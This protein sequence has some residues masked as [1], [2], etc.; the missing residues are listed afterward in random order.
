MED[1]GLMLL[2]FTH[3][4]VFAIHFIFPQPFLSIF[5]MLLSFYTFRYLHPS[6]HSPSSHPT[7]I[8][9]LLSYFLNSFLSLPSLIFRFKFQCIASKRYPCLLSLHSHQYSVSVYCCSSIYCLGFSLCS[10]LALS[11]TFLS[12]SSTFFPPFTPNSTP[13]LSTASRQFT[14]SA[15]LSRPLALSFIFISTSSTFFPPF[16]P[17]STL[18]LYDVSYQFHLAISLSIPAL[19]CFRFQS[20][21]STGSPCSLRLH[22]RQYS[23]LAD[24]SYQFHLAIF[25]SSPAL[26]SL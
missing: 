5:S 12:T 23:F 21:Y 16:T 15:S 11:F 22:S 1:K 10:P 20:T 25:L 17:T 14:F 24:V 13:F 2:S 9:L 8:T 7:P 19:L 26:P 4:S 3:S 18:F 6:L